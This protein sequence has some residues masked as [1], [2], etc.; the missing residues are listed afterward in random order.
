VD[1][2]I[3]RQVVLDEKEMPQE[4]KDA[5]KLPHKAEIYTLSAKHEK[6]V[7]DLAFE[8]TG[9]VFTLMEKAKDEEFLARYGLEYRPEQYRIYYSAG[10]FG[11]E[12]KPRELASKQRV[13]ADKENGKFYLVQERQDKKE[14]L[15]TPEGKTV[16]EAQEADT[17]YIKEIQFLTKDQMRYFDVK[18][19]PQHFIYHY[20]ERFILESKKQEDI[21]PYIQVFEDNGRLYRAYVGIKVKVNGVDEKQKNV[22][23][24]TTYFRK[25]TIITTKDKYVKNSS[26]SLAEDVVIN[27][28]TLRKGTKIAVVRPYTPEPG[29]LMKVITPHRGTVHVHDFHE[30]PVRLKT[31]SANDEFAV[32]INGDGEDDFFYTAGMTISLDYDRGYAYLIEREGK[33]YIIPA[34]VE[35]GINTPE[36]LRNAKENMFID[37]SAPVA[38]AVKETAHEGRLTKYRFGIPEKEKNFLSLFN[39]DFVKAFREYVEA[40]I[41]R[42]DYPAYYIHLLNDFEKYLHIYTTAYKAFNREGKN[43]QEAEQQ[44]RRFALK[45]LMDALREDQ[46]RFYKKIRASKEVRT[47]FD[48]L[49]DVIEQAKIKEEALEDIL[50]QLDKVIAQAERVDIHLEGLLEAARRVKEAELERTVAFIGT[51]R[52]IIEGIQNFAAQQQLLANAQAGIEALNN[53]LQVL[54]ADANTPWSIAWLTAQRDIAQSRGASA[55]EIGRWQTLINNYQTRLNEIGSPTQPRTELYYAT[56]N[57]NFERQ[58]L[59]LIGAKLGMDFA[60]AGIIA[61]SATDSKN[62]KEVSRRRFWMRV[63]TTSIDI[64]QRLIGL[65]FQEIERQQK[66]Q[67]AEYYNFR[68]E[69]ILNTQDALVDLAQIEATLGQETVASAQRALDDAA[70]HLEEAQGYVTQVEDN[71]N[72]AQQQYVRLLGIY[73]QDESNP[74][75]QQAAGNVEA[76]R[77]ELDRARNGVDFYQGE[78]TSA[79]NYQRLVTQQLYEYQNPNRGAPQTTD[80]VEI[81]QTRRDQIRALV[82]GRDLSQLSGE[83]LQHIFLQMDIYARAGEVEARGFQENWQS[84]QVEIVRAGNT[85]YQG[86]VNSLSADITVRGQQLDAYLE[87]ATAGLAAAEL[88]EQSPEFLDQANQ[89]NITIYSADYY[90]RLIADIQSQQTQLQDVRT[91]LDAGFNWETNPMGSFTN[92]NNSRL[93]NLEFEDLRA[94]QGYDFLRI[95]RTEDLIREDLNRPEE[96]RRTPEQIEARLDLEAN[97]PGTDLYDARV[98]TETTASDLEEFRSEAQEPLYNVTTLQQEEA[99]LENT[100]IRREDAWDSF[101]EL[102]D[103]LED[104]NAQRV[105]IFNATRVPFMQGGLHKKDQIPLILNALSAFGGQYLGPLAGILGSVRSIVSAFSDR[106]AD[107]EL[108]ENIEK[109][110][111]EREKMLN[112]LQRLMDDQIRMMRETGILKQDITNARIFGEEIEFDARN[113]ITQN[114]EEFAK[115][116]ADYGKTLPLERQAEFGDNAQRL[117]ILLKV[118]DE[119]TRRFILTETELNAVAK[120]TELKDPY[121]TEE[122][123]RQIKEGKVK[124]VFA[125]FIRAGAFLMNGFTQNTRVRIPVFGKRIW[126]VVEPLQELGL[127]PMQGGGL[128]A[129]RGGIRF[130]E[131]SE[132]GKVNIAGEVGLRHSEKVE[133]QG[134]QNRLGKPWKNLPG[135]RRDY[136]TRDYWGIYGLTSIVLDL[137]NGD[138]F[139]GFSGYGEYNPEQGTMMAG[140]GAEYR[141]RIKDELWFVVRGGALYLYGKDTATYDIPTQIPLVSMPCN[142]SYSASSLIAKFNVGVRKERETDP[143]RY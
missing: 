7:R 25:D 6:K 80:I 121:L 136:E 26:Y 114:A 65:R 141:K 70:A 55:T 131:E 61:G 142:Y 137:D 75:V 126:I 56:Q 96:E 112:E 59:D 125:D 63:S 91:T 23:N 37:P 103:S 133:D 66:A 43:A 51:I 34:V 130:V 72:E 2:G 9:R 107:R 79:T 13:Y 78:V 62:L 123:K 45:E 74:L 35:Y 92:L 69:N 3:F 58:K 19:I 100:T 143:S 16:R 68:I 14:Y 128:P 41:A 10:L 88:A 77:L 18:L 29:I 32:D 53:E 39:A 36:K 67:G 54:N 30:A 108:V 8:E 52:S 95:Q 111:V 90:R 132:D 117:V 44:A 50:D 4:G 135:W 94:Q 120:G 122:Q 33:K 60:K 89:N 106:K 38:E 134:V 28:A 57:I 86:Q 127:Q 118:F 15:V 93:S 27:G 47:Y 109:T 124:E 110:S 140:G 104:A 85:Y 49:R 48:R 20:T 97:T 138:T 139:L 5:F 42:G 115:I 12:R 87:S 129:T 22:S 102:R 98:Y 73:N 83:E 40:G 11:L 105:D 1:S 21:E 31:I 46:I 81:R 76:I 64:A 113:S 84:L 17:N 116:L 82:E 101:I 24:E 71:L 119:A 99:N